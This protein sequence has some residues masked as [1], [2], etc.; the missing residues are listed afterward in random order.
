MTDLTLYHN[1]RCSKSRGALDNLR[2]AC[3]PCNRQRGAMTLTEWRALYS[4]GR[5]HTLD[6]APSRNWL[7]DNDNE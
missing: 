2:P 6:L 5:G 3:Q 7:G 4:S 1:P